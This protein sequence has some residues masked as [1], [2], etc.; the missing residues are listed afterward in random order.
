MGKKYITKLK[1]MP[2]TTINETE[3]RLKV[4]CARQ[5]GNLTLL[6]I[7]RASLIFYEN[8]GSPSPYVPVPLLLTTL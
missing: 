2:E 8:E 6:K 7:G 1:G 5:K 3:N 4:T